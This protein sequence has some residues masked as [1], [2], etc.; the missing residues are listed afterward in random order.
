MCKHRSTTSTTRGSAVIGVLAAAGI[1]VSLMQTL[2]VP[3]L[4]D[5]PRLLHTTAG[6]ASWTITATL[7]AG[8]VATPV[9]GRL[10]DLYGKRRLLLV[11]IALLVLGSVICALT[12]SLTAM[13]VGR[14]LQGM[15]MSV[16]PLGISLMRD[17]VPPERLGGALGLMS[18]SLGV[19]AALGLPAAALIAQHA[20]WHVLFWGAAGLGMVMALLVL[21]LVPGTPATAAGGFDLVGALGVG[22]GLVC[23]LLPVS[24]GADWGW[25]S[26]TTLG[27]FAAAI[28][29]LLA[30][31]WWELRTPAPLVDLRTTAKRQV[32]MTNL[33]SVAVGFAMY[34]MSLIAPQLLA[35]PKETGYGLGQS[36]MAAGLWMAPSGLVMMA[37]SPYA[38]K[39]SAA[40][41]PKTSL[42][43]GALAIAAGYALALPLM[44]HLWGVLVVSSVVSA[45][46]GLAYAAVP[47]L[48]MG[49]VP[50]D[51][52][53]AANGLNSLMRSIG[54][55][56]SSAV[57]GVV[58]AHMTT[59]MGSVTVPSQAGFR[60]GFV[61][62]GAG[63]VLAAL[64]TLCLPGR[65]PH[66]P[67]ASR[68]P[69]LRSW[70]FERPRRWP[71][72]SSPGR[73]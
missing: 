16:V 4:P 43:L 72:V 15:G 20:D 70:P 60:T 37:V 57:V 40:R 56:A 50:V 69:S 51:E 17:I 28:V 66:S 68:R 73:T 18:S 53:A 26:P 46:I 25:S 63:A 36:M 71:H 3:L 6:N 19:G 9:I 64:V 62:G 58:L 35:L 13:V 31:G 2:V 5:L 59:R 45:G 65:P 33:A 42:L 32:L 23:L 34:A 67:P 44:G 11:S 61:L 48:I 14:A 52:T 39:L 49:A 8:A 1:T 7:L 38:A 47:M 30:W 27:L 29:V 21:F 41:G 55:S 10:G 22:T 24:K 12:D 54:T